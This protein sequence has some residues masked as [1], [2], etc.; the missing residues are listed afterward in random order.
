MLHK[1]VI[2]L[3]TFSFLLNSCYS[4]DDQ[5]SPNRIKNYSTR[6][7]IITPKAIINKK[8]FNK[9]Y[10][11]QSYENF[12]D[13]AIVKLTEYTNLVPHIFILDNKK[14]S[15]FYSTDLKSLKQFNIAKQTENPTSIVVSRN[16]NIYI[17]DKNKKS[18]FKYSFNETGIQYDSKIYSGII[19]TD[20][21]LD[22]KSNLYILDEKTNSILYLNSMGYPE[23]QFNKKN[24]IKTYINKN[25]EKINLSGLRSISIDVSGNI[26]V[27]AGFGNEL[28]TFSSD[29]RTQKVV[30]LSPKIAASSLA[31]L[32]NSLYLVSK[33]TN[34]IFILNKLTFKLLATFDMPKHSVPWG[35]INNITK[36][37]TYSDF[38]TFTILGDNG[39]EIFKEGK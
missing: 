22:D 32:N 13:L 28:L 15:I 10:P 6:Q 4:S 27:I 17:G 21:T 16:G 12:V 24:S 18:I 35:T 11:Q 37:S 31:L 36:I 23:K 5:K 2:F 19:P 25:N 7:L 34:S 33:S 1:Q 38:N 9:V 30:Y 8:L 29:G 20:M 26:Y 14:R 3:I 39:I